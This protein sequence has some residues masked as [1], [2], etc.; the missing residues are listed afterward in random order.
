MQLMSTQESQDWEEEEEEEEEEQYNTAELAIGVIE[1]D[2]TSSDYC[3]VATKTTLNVA[4]TR[5]VSPSNYGIEEEDDNE[6]TK[7]GSIIESTVLTEEE[8]FIENGTG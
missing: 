6:V 4:I 7:Y 3:E 8:I 5:P 2:S 1:N